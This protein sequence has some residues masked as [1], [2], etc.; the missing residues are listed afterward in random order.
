MFSTLLQCLPQAQEKE[1]FRRVQP[2]ESSP[3][4]AS[5]RRSH[6]KCLTYS[7][8]T[9]P[10]AVAEVGNECDHPQADYPPYQVE[11]GVDE[12][13]CEFGKRHKL[14]GFVSPQLAGQRTAS[15]VPAWLREASEPVGS[16]HT[17]DTLVCGL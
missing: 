5:E 8:I 17:S 1:V 7:S 4:I 2:G 6:S 9:S 14:T 16:V 3:Q 10:K 15:S 13:G 11:A 12:F